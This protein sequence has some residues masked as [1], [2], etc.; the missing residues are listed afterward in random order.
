MA[1]CWTHFSIGLETS[2][3]GTG[4]ICETRAIP[5][6]VIPAKAG[7]YFASHWRCAADRLD[8][9]FRGNDQC[10]EGDPIP[11]DTS[12]RA[13]YR[14]PQPTCGFGAGVTKAASTMPHRNRSIKVVS[15]HPARVCYDSTPKHQER[16][17]GQTIYGKETG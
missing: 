3:G 14:F 11:N 13:G 12:T 15:N 1:L 8:S 16:D 9:R 10:F 17:S 5:S 6:A 2:R 7:I 4:V